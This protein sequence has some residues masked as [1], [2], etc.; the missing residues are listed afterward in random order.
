[1][2]KHKVKMVQNDTGPALMFDIENAD[3]SPYNLTGATVRLKLKSNVTGNITNGAHQVCTNVGT[4]SNRCQYTWVSG[5]IP[6][7]GVYV[8]DLEIT[9]SLGKIQTEYEY[10][11][12]TVRPEVG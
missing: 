5:D 11:E 2:A 12:V 8:A 10:V 3:G 1:M 9:D 7:A 4:P 6:D